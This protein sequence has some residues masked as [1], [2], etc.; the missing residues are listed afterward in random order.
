VR[1]AIAAISEG[2]WTTIGYPQAVFDEQL[3]Q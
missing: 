1:R 3:E 2:A